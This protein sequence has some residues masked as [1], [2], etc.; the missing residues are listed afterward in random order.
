MPFGSIQILSAPD[1]FTATARL[2]THGVGTSI[3]AMTSNCCSRSS[4]FFSFFLSDFGTRRRGVTTGVAPCSTSRWNIPGSILSS[5][6]ICCCDHT[7]LS[8][9]RN[10]LPPKQKICSKAGWEVV[11][12]TREGG[13]STK[14]VPTAISSNCEIS[15]CAAIFYARKT[16]KDHTRRH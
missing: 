1:L 12:A 8:Y 6:H 11:T 13:R 2:L 5:L 7:R 3:G 10:P 9:G 15:H 14:R 16:A 4:S